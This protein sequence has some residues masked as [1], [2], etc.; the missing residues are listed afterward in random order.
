MMRKGLPGIADKVDRAQ[1]TF[2]CNEDVFPIASLNN[3]GV[4]EAI[5]QNRIF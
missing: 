3:R 5:L 2:A 4:K 1:A